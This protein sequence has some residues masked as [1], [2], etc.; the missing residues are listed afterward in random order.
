[1]ISL[2]KKSKNAKDTENIMGYEGQISQLYWSGFRIITKLSYFTRTHQHSNDPYNQALNYAYAIIYNR[3][4]SALLKEGLNIYYSFLHS[5]NYNKPSLVFDM[6]EIF[7]QPIV[8]REIISIITKN[9][10]LTQTKGRL[11]ENTKK[12]IIQ[13][14]QKR[15]VSFT[16]TRYGRTTYL[17]LISFEANSLKLAFERT[18]KNHHFFIAKY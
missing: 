13:H 11:S 8:D 10:K 2:L 16:K 6:V 5:T 1:M 9:Q 7:R 12:I 17:N 4:Q 3:V 18:E 14:I 15:L